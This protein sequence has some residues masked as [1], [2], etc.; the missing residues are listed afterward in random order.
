MIAIMERLVVAFWQKCPS[1]WI[2][3][4]FKCTG[5]GGGKTDIETV[6]AGARDLLGDFGNINTAFSH[7]LIR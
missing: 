4:T 7:S 3:T 2:F 5:S 6:S 1:N